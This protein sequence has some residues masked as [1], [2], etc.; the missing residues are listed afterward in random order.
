MNGRAGAI[1]AGCN[2]VTNL[3]QNLPVTPFQLGGTIVISSALLNT[4]W[5][6]VEQSG[7]SSG[8]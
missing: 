3:L 6:G 7:S 2:G 4:D 8:S 1:A 5:R